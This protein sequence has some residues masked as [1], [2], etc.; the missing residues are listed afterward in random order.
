MP[1][2]SI[3]P[4]TTDRPRQLLA[5][6]LDRE[7]AADATASS[8]RTASATRPSDTPTGDRTCQREAP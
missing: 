5:R 6:R 4:A 2:I 8:D 1:R 3:V 7:P